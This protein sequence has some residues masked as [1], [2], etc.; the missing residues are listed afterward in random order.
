MNKITCTSH[1]KEIAKLYNTPHK[2]N[3]YIYKNLKFI[4]KVKK[5]K[6]RNRQEDSLPYQTHNTKKKRKQET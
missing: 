6:G 1:K 2:E 5:N 4:F 3:K